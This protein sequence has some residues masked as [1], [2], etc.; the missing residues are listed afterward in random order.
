MATAIDKFLK[1]Q[2]MMSHHSRKDMRHG[3]SIT[4]KKG[5]ITVVECDG[6]TWVSDE[7]GIDIGD[8]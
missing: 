5:K 7:E 2:N 8:T 6:Y 3:L 4:I 1:A